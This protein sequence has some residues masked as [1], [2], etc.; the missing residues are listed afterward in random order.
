MLERVHDPV[1]LAPL[2]NGIMVPRTIALIE[3]GILIATGSYLLMGRTRRF[4]GPIPSL[5]AGA[6][7]AWLY[8][9][10]TPEVLAA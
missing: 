8:H 9:R 2:L 4:T 7:G 6:L 10:Y 1:V 5:G 3:M